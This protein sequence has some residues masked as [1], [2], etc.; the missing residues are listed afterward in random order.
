MIPKMAAV[1]DYEEFAK[2]TLSKPYYENIAGY[3]EDGIAKQDNEKDFEL[4]KLKQRGMANMK[5]FK[6]LETTILGQKVQSPIGV[7]PLS[8]QMLLKLEGENATAQATKEF[9]SVF[10]LSGWSNKS[11]EEVAQSSPGGIK[12]F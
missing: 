7:A 10:V 12:L 3:A 8:Q 4:I 2:K 6:G 1:S 11:V 9:G 5:Y